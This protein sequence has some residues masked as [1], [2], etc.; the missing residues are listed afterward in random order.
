MRI[1]LDTNVLIGALITK[2]TPPYQLQQAMLS[3]KI[4]LV[5]STRQLEELGR[6]LNYEKLKPYIR[7]GEASA[8][9]EMIDTRA[10]IIEAL[11]EVDL[12]PDPDDNAILATGI[13]G[14][15]D[16]IVSGDKTGMLDLNEVNG[17]PIVTSRQALQRIE[18]QNQ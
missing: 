8:L 2:G 14:N 9:L 7:E 18:A 15:A 5:T 17:I 6:V 3:G 4:E 12:S 16:L 11:P 1:V 13:A 10:V